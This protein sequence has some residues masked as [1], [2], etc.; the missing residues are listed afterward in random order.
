MSKE[1]ECFKCKADTGY[2]EDTP[3]EDRHHSFI[4]GVEDSRGELH[5]CPVCWVEMGF[6]EYY[7][8]D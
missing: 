6:K 3:V 7:K 4:S 8:R 5:F 2:T 1:I